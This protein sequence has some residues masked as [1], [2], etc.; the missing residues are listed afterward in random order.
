[1]SKCTYQDIEVR[2][3]DWN[4]WTIDQFGNLDE[5]VGSPEQ[6]VDI[7]EWYCS[8]CDE[9]FDDTKLIRNHVTLKEEIDD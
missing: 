9:K 2:C 6:G 5:M 4:Y 7:A 8:N 1:M 3:H